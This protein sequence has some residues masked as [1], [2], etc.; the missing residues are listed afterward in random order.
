MEE[1][2]TWMQAATGIIGLVNAAVRLGAVVLRRRAAAR[3]GSVPAGPGDGG[4]GD[5]T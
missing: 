1:W 3:R 5:R 4:A 2:Q